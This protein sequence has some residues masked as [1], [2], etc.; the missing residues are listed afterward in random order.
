MQKKLVPDVVSN[1]ELR[2]IAPGETVRAA[3]KTLA[4]RRI[5]ALLVMEGEKLAGI[6]SERD[7]TTRV[8]AAGQDPDAT[9]VS[10]IMTR[11]PICAGPDETALAALLRMQKGGFRHLPVVDGGKVVGMVSVR[12][13]YAS[14]KKDL[15]ADLEARDQFIFDTGYGRG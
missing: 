8:V 11:D 5:G 15:E 7:I 6:L 2:G 14:V 1:Q 4:E 12:D 13:L 9:K 3:A 10:D